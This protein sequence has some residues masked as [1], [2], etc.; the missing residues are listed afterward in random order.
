MSKSELAKDSKP[1]T[2]K[3]IMCLGANLQHGVIECLQKR[4]RNAPIFQGYGMT[5]MNIATLPPSQTDKVGSAGKL[6]ADMEA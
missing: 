3:Y 1:D 4:F 5:E 6:F 2:V